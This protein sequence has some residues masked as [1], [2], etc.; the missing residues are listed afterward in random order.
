MH[1]N[2]LIFNNFLDFVEGMSFYRYFERQ[3]EFVGKRER[4]SLEEY[5]N[6]NDLVYDFECFLTDVGIKEKIILKETLKWC[7][8]NIKDDIT[9]LIIKR[10][11]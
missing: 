7:N 6:K 2:F 8:N 3:F 9:L 11:K 4:S 5:I 1:L 10:K